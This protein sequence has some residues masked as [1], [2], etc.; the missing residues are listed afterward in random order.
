MNESDRKRDETTDVRERLL[1]AA[2]R[3][4]GLIGCELDAVM[5]GL[6]LLESVSI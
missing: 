1:L 4:G 2:E 6:I 3:R 5:S